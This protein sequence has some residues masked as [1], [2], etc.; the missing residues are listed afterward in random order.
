MNVFDLVGRAVEPRAWVNVTG[1]G[2]RARMSN[3]CTTPP[4]YAY[5]VRVEPRT[6]AAGPQHSGPQLR[7]GGEGTCRWQ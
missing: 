4:G 6:R 5:R 2:S 7:G 3:R 1:A